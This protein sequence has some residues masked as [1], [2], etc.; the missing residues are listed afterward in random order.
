M[1][2]GVCQLTSNELKFNTMSATSAIGPTS[3]ASTRLTFAPNGVDVL[4]FTF[5]EC[6][7]LNGAHRLLGSFPGNFVNSGSYVDHPYNEV[8]SVGTLKFQ[9]S[10][11][12]VVGFEGVQHLL[13]EGHPLKLD[14]GL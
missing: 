6:G 5:K 7:A 8:K 10:N 13:S 9:S 3:T 11:G 12:P 14:A 4:N 1:K 2:P